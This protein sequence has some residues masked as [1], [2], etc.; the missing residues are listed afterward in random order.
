L[1][2]AGS[3]SREK[4]DKN[5][6]ANRWL[7]KDLLRYEGEELPVVSFQPEG[8]ELERQRS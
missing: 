3:V 1:P 6:W 5:A 4:V 2:P 8:Q 7:F